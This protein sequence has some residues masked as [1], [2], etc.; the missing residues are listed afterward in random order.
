MIQV[1]IV[2]EYQEKDTPEMLPNFQVG[3]NSNGEIDLK[4]LVESLRGEDFLRAESSISYLSPDDPTLYIYCGDTAVL[5]EAK[6][7]PVNA[8][9]QEGQV[10]G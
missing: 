8:I 10:S 4:A 9:N 2:L 7:I 1:S 5:N 3:I 6:N